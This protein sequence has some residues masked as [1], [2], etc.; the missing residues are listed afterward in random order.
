VRCLQLRGGGGNLLLKRASQVT[1]L[2]AVVAALR[3]LLYRLP[4]V[5]AVVVKA[6]VVVLL[7]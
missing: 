1:H 2:V 4:A 7:P 6:G 5:V 3:A